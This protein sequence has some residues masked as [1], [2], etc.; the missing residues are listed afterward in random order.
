MRVRLKS[1][2]CVL[3]FGFTSH[4][5]AFPTLST[6]SPNRFRISY[7]SGFEHDG[8]ASTAICSASLVRFKTSLDSDKAILLTN[9]HC[10]K[11]SFG[12]MLKPGEV[13]F[14]R[15]FEMGADILNRNG[16]A[17]AS[18][19]SHRVL[20]ATMTS[21]DL[22]L[23]EFDETYSQIE[24]L[25]GAKALVLSDM[26]PSPGTPIQIASGYWNRTYSCSVDATIPTLKEDVYTFNDSIR[27]SQPGCEIVGGTS[28][29]PLISSIT[30]EVVGINNTT[31]EDG[32]SCTMNNPCEVD[33]SGQ[34][35][36]AKGRGYG[37][38][39]YQIYGCLNSARKMDLT[40]PTCSLAKP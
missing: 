20:Y 14:N 15:P 11:E 27:Y 34:V 23:F 32:E 24:S 13:L 36:A 18:L 17:I 1:F 22:S 4:A 2:L 29:S 28:G 40:L 35:T 16:D 33:R 10:A 31:N 7:A 5:L 30:G 8:I 3:I 19:H 6:K 37:Q 26:Q 9:G 39:T 21:T 25:S 12:P 38:Q